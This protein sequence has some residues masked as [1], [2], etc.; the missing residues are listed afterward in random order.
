MTAMEKLEA[1]T[2][3]RVMHLIESKTEDVARRENLDLKKPADL[4]KAYSAVCTEDPDLYNLYRRVS[5]VPVRK[6]SLA[7]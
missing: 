2:R 7:D 4:V 6:L 1:E 3:Q 5:S